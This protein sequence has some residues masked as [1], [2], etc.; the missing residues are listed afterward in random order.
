M[1]ELCELRS[2]YATSKRNNETI[3]PVDTINREAL[4]AGA[5]RDESG[6]GMTLASR[7]L[8]NSCMS[9]AVSPSPET[10]FAGADLGSAGA[11]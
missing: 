10:G 8:S 7:S 5:R 3:S 6:W 1:A 2:R 4:D 11:T 9:A